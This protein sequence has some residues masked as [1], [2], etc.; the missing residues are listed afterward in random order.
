L[1]PLPTWWLRHPPLNIVGPE[2]IP[3]LN[4][5]V[6]ALE[7]DEQVKVVVFDSAVDGFFLTHGVQSRSGRFNRDN[8]RAGD[9]RRQ[10]AGARQRHAFR[11]WEKAILSLGGGH[12]IGARRP[13]NGAAAPFDRGRPPE[14]LLGAF[15]NEAIAETKRL[16]DRNSLPPTR[17]SLPSRARQRISSRVEAL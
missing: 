16:V 9:A 14:V 6:T 11:Q 4:E 13:S 5:I 1:F 10:R 3:D 15:N 2:S 12:G 17:R 8:S 7:T